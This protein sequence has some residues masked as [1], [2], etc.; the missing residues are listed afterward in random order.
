MRLIP[1]ALSL[2]IV[3]C[4]NNITIAESLNLLPDPIIVAASEN[5]C[6]STITR[7][8]DKINS[9][10]SKNITYYSK[11]DK[12]G[13]T[14]STKYTRIDIKWL[15]NRN[16]LNSNYANRRD[17]LLL[18]I[19]EYNSL[20]ADILTNCTTGTVCTRK[21]ESAERR[22][23]KLNSQIDRTLEKWDLSLVK[24]DSR[25]TSQIQKAEEVHSE[26]VA[27]YEATIASNNSDISALNNSIV[28]CNGTAV[29]CSIP[30]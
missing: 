18:R 23:T 30:N 6:Q 22:I 4:L 20:R 14:L 24:N 11:I 17:G 27:K 5:Q 1:L 26:K 8:T 2:V 12:S 7:N 16:R 9:L 15:N 10:C 3:N 13:E 29:S 19:A 25:K 28:A 21:L